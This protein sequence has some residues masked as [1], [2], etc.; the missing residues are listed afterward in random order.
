MLTALIG[1]FTLDVSLIV[2]YCAAVFIIVFAT[3]EVC[4]GV[5]QHRTI[6]NGESKLLPFSKRLHQV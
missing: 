1:H 2:F 4:A 6:N 5:Q 3:N